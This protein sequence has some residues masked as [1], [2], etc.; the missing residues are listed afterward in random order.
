MPSKY[1]NEFSVPKDFPSVLK[2]FTR[3]VLRGQPDNI[4]EFGALYFSDLLVQAEA[5]LAVGG[6]AVCRLTPTELEDLLSSL[7]VEADKDGSGSL[8]LQEFKVKASRR[9]HA[10]IPGVAACVFARAHF[11]PALFTN[12]R[13]FICGIGQGTSAACPH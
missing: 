3:E 8:S 4:Y 5:A 1:G 12:S 13:R 2:S 9:A 7:F 6:T 10:A 11:C